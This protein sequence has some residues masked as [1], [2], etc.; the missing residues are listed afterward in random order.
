[1]FRILSTFTSGHSLLQFRMIRGAS[2]T[3]AD[4]PCIYPLCHDYILSPTNEMQFTESIQLFFTDDPL[5]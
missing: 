2:L 5:Q 1:M 3:R 4:K